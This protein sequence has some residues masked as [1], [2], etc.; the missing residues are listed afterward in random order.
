MQ[1]VYISGAVI[2]FRS[3]P[4]FI[5]TIVFRADKPF[6]YMI[7]DQNQAQ[8]LFWGSIHQLQ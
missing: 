2:S 4:R 8:G 3:M 6:I 5:P 7:K 1:I